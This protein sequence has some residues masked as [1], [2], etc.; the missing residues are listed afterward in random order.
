MR[1]HVG[2]TDVVWQT[3]WNPTKPLLASCSADKT[4]QLYS[5]TFTSPPL[6]SVATN[7][8]T[9]HTRTVRSVAW[10]PSGKAL[11][12]ASFDSNISI[13]EPS[14]DES[15]EDIDAEHIEWECVG[16][17]EGHETECKS[18][19]YSSDGTLLASCSRDKTVW[20][21]EGVS[22]P[23]FILFI[24]TSK[25]KILVQP[26]AEFECLGVLMHHTQDIKHVAWH[27]KEQ[28]LASASYD[29]TINLYVDD[30]DDDWYPVAKLIGH[31]STVWCISWSPCGNYF[32]SSSDDLTVRIWIR[33]K[34]T[35][36]DRWDCIK[37]LKEHE[38]PIY[39]VTWGKGQSGKDSL[40]WIASTGGDGKIIVWNI[41]GKGADIETIKLASLEAS[42]GVSDTN[43]VSW[44][45]HEGMENILAS[46]G[47]D[48]TV[49]IWEVI[50][51]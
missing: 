32:T 44:C 49:R 5:Y 48:H 28:I 13:W 51:V 30:P 1:S 43:S 18:V 27:P 12:T 33:V 7:I 31:T 46:A 10:A 23:K 41:M 50:P 9:D 21:W 36:G 47:D 37:I 39:S 4:V 34:E 22:T 25:G 40:G 19:A 15:W 42:H 26:D 8:S 17:L 11:A 29:D 6:F 24:P 45:L 38:R 14:R 3:A 2:H 20:I 35:R 16:T